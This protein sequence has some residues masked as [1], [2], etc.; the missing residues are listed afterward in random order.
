MGGGMDG[1]GGMGSMGD[2]GGAGV[3]PQNL[4]EER[5]L[6]IWRE[7]SRANNRPFDPD[8]VRG[9]YRQYMGSGR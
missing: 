3:N 7:Y 5:Y 4:T 9:W 1:Y 6:D 8:L 2:R